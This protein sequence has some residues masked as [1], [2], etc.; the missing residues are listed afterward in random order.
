LLA[1]SLY[2]NGI[3]DMGATA[4]AAILNKTKI[5][6]LECVTPLQC[7][8]LCQQPASHTVPLSISCRLGG[9]TIGDK[10]GSALA[11]ILKETQITELQCAPIESVRFLRE[12]R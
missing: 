3:G 1:H 4:L 9:N 2:G 10:G 6:E 11:A 5:I 12:R 7:L 8:L